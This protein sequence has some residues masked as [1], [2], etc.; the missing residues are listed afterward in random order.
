MQN[1]DSSDKNL[2]VVACN[3]QN[4]IFNEIQKALP[5]NSKYS[6]SLY[7]SYCR[8]MFSFKVSH[9]FRITY[10]VISTITEE[11]GFYTMLGK[12]FLYYLITVAA[13]FKSLKSELSIGTRLV[14]NL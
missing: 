8:R 6:R 5:K 11:Y 7:N 10:D 2:P 14:A 4:P 12:K 1:E 13:F 9:I 3:S